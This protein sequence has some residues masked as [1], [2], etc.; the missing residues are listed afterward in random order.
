MFGALCL[1]AGWWAGPVHIV[2]RF[3]LRSPATG[4][5][6]RDPFQMDSCC[7]HRVFQV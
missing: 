1:L 7:T 4:G 6:T 3:S 2:M 5:T